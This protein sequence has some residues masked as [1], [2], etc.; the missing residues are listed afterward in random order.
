[1]RAW[2][3]RISGQVTRKPRSASLKIGLTKMRV[4][5]ARRGFTADASAIA[6]KVRDAFTD[7]TADRTVRQPLQALEPATTL[8][9]LRRANSTILTVD[10]SHFTLRLFKNLRLSKKYGIAV[11]MSGLETP[12][13]TYHIT[14]KQVNPAWHVPNSAW[15]GSLAGQV[16]PGG[17]PN[18]P[19]VARWLGIQD[20]VG[21]H[22]TN[23]PWSIGSAASHGCIRMRPDDVIDLYGRVPVGTPVLIR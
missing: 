23:E 16:I 22:G 8:A 10:R 18:N 7:P 9:E 15:A 2:A 5:K 21:I 17:A 4:T 1:V 20:G 19:L 13:G 11:G 3:D 14:S 12:A 6:T